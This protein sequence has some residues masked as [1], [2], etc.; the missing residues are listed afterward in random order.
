MFDTDTVLIVQNS[1]DPQGQRGASKASLSLLSLCNRSLQTE[2]FSNKKTPT[3]TTL[4]C[5]PFPL[6]PPRRFWCRSESRL[7]SL[8]LDFQNHLTL[9]LFHFMR[10]GQS[11][12]TA[13]GTSQPQCLTLQDGHCPHC[14]YLFY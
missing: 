4:V 5:S 11:P 9:G 3:N 7:S 2:T 12:N 10:W 14:F 13:A 1:K 8:L 6:C